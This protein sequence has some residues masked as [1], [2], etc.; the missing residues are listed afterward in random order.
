[1]PTKKAIIETVYL[2]PD[3]FG[4]LKEILKDTKTKDD[5]IT[6]EDVREWKSKRSFGQKATPR[7]SKR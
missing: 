4:S 7:G 2:G 3:G 1:M 6:H 5:T